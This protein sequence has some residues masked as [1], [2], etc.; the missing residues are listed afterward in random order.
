ML[1]KIISEISWYLLFFTTVISFI[2]RKRFGPAPM[3]YLPYYLIYISL[4]EIIALLI[5]NSSIKY[6]VWWYNIMGNGIYLFYLYLY[7]HLIESTKFKKV[8]QIFVL[9]Y[10]A[11]YLVNYLF[12]S[13]NWNTFQS[14]PFSLGSFFVLI[15][16]FWYLIELFQ[17]DEIMYL[18]N[19]I[20]FW[21][22]VGLLFHVIIQSPSFV[23]ATYFKKIEFINNPHISIFSTFMYLSNIIM[24]A[25]YLIGI[26]NSKSSKS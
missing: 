6:N 2:Y 4:V 23:S 19:M 12:L 5:I 8:I 22:S 20:S 9:V 1:I 15:S 16:V 7:Y 13:E 3:K 14:F 26:W 11:F 25:F 24:Y 18:G 10:L 17:S 21:V